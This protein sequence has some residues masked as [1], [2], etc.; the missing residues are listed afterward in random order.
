M[1]YWNAPVDKFC[2][3]GISNKMKGT[4]SV[5][6]VFL[7][8]S[9]RYSSWLLFMDCLSVSDYISELRDLKSRNIFV[10]QSQYPTSG[11]IKF[12]YVCSGAK[13]YFLNV[14]IVNFD[15]LHWI[16]LKYFIHFQSGVSQYNLRFHWTF[17][18]LMM[19]EFNIIA[20]PFSILFF[21]TFT[22]L[23]S[24]LRNGTKSVEYG[25]WTGISTSRS[26]KLAAFRKQAYS[27]CLWHIPV[28]NCSHTFGLEYLNVILK[29]L[30]FSF[31][32]TVV[33]SNN[34]NN[35]SGD[36]IVVLV[37]LKLNK[38]NQVGEFLKTNNW[39]LYYNFKLSRYCYT[40]NS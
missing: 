37:F 16:T 15:I 10:F 27:N 20:L 2:G 33:V 13:S 1:V 22:T 30:N 9:T 3:S 40:Q 36:N 29:S 12:I 6:L 18:E 11:L 19:F 28:F 7:F 26:C 34:M 35:I 17:N 39:N 21:G 38:K 14:F 31:M 24:L 8:T 5:F 25:G 32:N 4:S 23:N